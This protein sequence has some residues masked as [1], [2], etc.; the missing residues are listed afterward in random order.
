MTTWRLQL[1]PRS[2]WAT[3]WRADSLFGAICWAWVEL[4]PETFEEMLAGFA[5]PGDPPFIV[6]D[7]FPGDLLPLPL[8]VEPP[9]AER[10]LKPPIYVSQA[11]FRE[12]LTGGCASSA[13]VMDQPFG[14]GS[15][16]RT[17]IDRELGSA[18]EGQLFEIETQHLPKK[19]ETLS[20]YVRSERYLAQLVDCFKALALTGFGKK[21]SS[22]LG[23]FDMVEKPQRCEWLDQVSGTNGFVTLSHFVPAASDPT[24]GQWR[25][26]VTYPKFQANAVSNVFKGAILMMTPGS[27]FDTSGPPA[28]PRY[29]SMIQMGRPE[30]PN[31]IHYALAFAVPLRWEEEA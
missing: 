4:F 26:H 9:L 18:A 14:S 25:L 13:D 28:K 30:I 1:R 12:L 31:A 16:V 24:D 21:R 23:A 20:I 7:G 11:G 8:H 2:S 15:Q 22:G 6:S 3:P 17:A 27:V 10:K 19:F 5:G 29:G